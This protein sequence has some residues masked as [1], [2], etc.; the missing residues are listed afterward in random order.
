MPSTNKLPLSSG[1][2]TS[3][4]PTI[5]IPQLQVQLNDEEHTSLAKINQLLFQGG[6]GGGVPSPA[7]GS[8]TAVNPY[9]ALV[10]GAGTLPPNLT[11]LS[12][13]NQGTGIATFNGVNV[14]AGLSINI[15]AA[16]GTRFNQVAYNAN[17]NNVYLA[18]A[19][20]V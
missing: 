18:G 13:M 5:T 1:S 6:G 9:Y 10:T 17:G 12:F 2:F 11:S 3:T 4:A 7:S 20:L 8:Y 15:E 19:Q 16:P 14:P